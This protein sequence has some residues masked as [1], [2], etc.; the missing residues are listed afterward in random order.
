VHSNV[1]SKEEKERV[2]RALE[3]DKE[4]RYAL[5]GLLG[6]KEILDR[7]IS[8]E[9]RFTGLEERIVKLEERFA[10]LAE[11]F[12]KL[13]ERI[14]KL[15]E[16]V[17]KLEERLAELGERFAKLEERVLKLEKRAL[18]VEEEL[19]ENRRLI[20]VIAHRYGVISEEAF[21]SAMKYVIEEVFGVA[22][23]TKWVYKDEEGFVYGYSSVIEV[24]VLVRDRDHVLIEI[25]SR[26][27]KSDVAELSRIGKLYERVKGI[28]PRLVIIGGFIDK[29]AYYLAKNIGVEIKPIT[30][31]LSSE[32]IDL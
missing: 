15:E 7:M 12:A 27:S 10:E 5:M 17:T 2:L 14:I 30:G 26:V 19:R 25:K 24:D 23:V 11:R 8:L 28:K 1:L 29:D 18:R 32:I 13:E 4:F 20:I 31:S 16:R 3:E 6:Y 22:Q 9:D 21:R